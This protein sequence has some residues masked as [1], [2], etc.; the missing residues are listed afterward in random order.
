MISKRSPTRRSAIAPERRHT[1]RSI[2]SAPQAAGASRA[3]TTTAA[4]RQSSSKAS[5]VFA[6]ATSEPSRSLPMQPASIAADAGR[7][8]SVL[9]RARIGVGREPFAQ[10]KAVAAR[11]DHG[12]PAIGAAH[13]KGAAVGRYQDVGLRRPDHHDDGAADQERSDVP[14]WGLEQA[15][16]H[17]A[18][19]AQQQGAGAERRHASQCSGK[20]RDPG[21]DGDHPF[22]AMAH[23]PPAI[24]VEPER[25]GE[26][27]STPHGITQA[28]TSGIASR[29]PTT[30]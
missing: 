15:E 2:T 17:E 3:L 22:D 21:R 6:M 29:L 8:R 27:P 1:R 4:R 5:T 12:E 11:L 20:A 18:K 13:G 14:Q 16:H 23:H 19:A 30:P 9:G 7:E 10:R 26:T 28:D 24:A 25:H